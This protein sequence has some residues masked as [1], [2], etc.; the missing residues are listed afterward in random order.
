MTWSSSDTHVQSPPS[1]ASYTATT[2]QCLAISLRRLPCPLVMSQPF[3]A[4]LLLFT[5]TIT[6]SPKA[7]KN[8]SV[9]RARQKAVLLGGK[10]NTF[11]YFIPWFTVCRISGSFSWS[12]S[13]IQG[14]QL[15]TPLSTVDSSEVV[16]PKAA[17]TL[18]SVGL[19]YE[20]LSVLI[21]H[22]CSL[23]D[24]PCDLNQNF[25]SQLICVDINGWKAWMHGFS[26]SF[27]RW[28][29]VRR[30]LCFQSFKVYKFNLSLFE[31][32]SE[33]LQLFS[34]KEEFHCG[35]DTHPSQ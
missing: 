35:F 31:S 14:R 29:C 23:L 5:H 6:S 20:A 27:L 11:F 22:L 21:L 13:Q 9:S 15:G 16:G 26:W 17:H 1:H 34:K 32:P 28:D 19:G 4:L 2:Q 24:E 18:G 25:M 12:G 10:R 30:R 3:T 8:P 33:L 7:L